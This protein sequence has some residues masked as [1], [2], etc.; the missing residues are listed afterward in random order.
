M[1]DWDDLRLVLQIHRLG[2]LTAAGQALG[3]NQSTVGRRL[4]ALQDGL[5]DQ[6]FERT[7]RGYVATPAGHR[8]ALAAERMAAVVDDL[9]AE[10]SGAPAGLEGPLRITAPDLLIA[11]F[12]AARLVSFAAHHP[13]LGIELVSDERPPAL[14]RRESDLA[15]RFAVPD[16]P[17]LFVR[18][19]GTVA[20]AVYAAPSYVVAAQLDPQERRTP[21]AGCF[22]GSD[23]IGPPEELST[24]PEALW[25][26]RLARGARPALRVDGALAQLA[27]VKTGLGLALLPCFLADPERLT[28]LTA[29]AACPTREL[30]LAVHRD[31]RNMPRLRSA[32]DFLTTLTRQERTTLTGGPH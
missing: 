18:R 27:A 16:R 14:S 3:L 23:A 32:I 31:L 7:P 1:T 4:A 29:P 24:G 15:L 28:R 30:W 21:D 26:A 8:L 6:L 13:G 25:F 2:S 11:S 10:L 12:L 9:Q 17:E 5:G 22:A 19:L 20:F